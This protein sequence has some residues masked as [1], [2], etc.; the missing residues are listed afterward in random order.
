MKVEGFVKLTISLNVCVDTEAV[1]ENQYGEIKITDP[2]TFFN[3]W[4]EEW[5]DGTGELMGVSE[6]ETDLSKC[7]DD[8]EDDDD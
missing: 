4:L 5:E 7:D 8:E 1:S 3:D 2:D 6:E